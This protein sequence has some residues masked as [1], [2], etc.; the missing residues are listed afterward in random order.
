[1]RVRSP[2][3][4]TSAIITVLPPRVMLAVPEMFARRETLLPL[5]W[6]F[7]SSGRSNWFEARG[8]E[9]ERT[10]SFRMNV[11]SMIIMGVERCR[12]SFIASWQ[13]SI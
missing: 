2:R 7:V 12:H 8:S 3:R 10:L 1:M 11:M 5:S 13:E 4:W 6:G 9:S